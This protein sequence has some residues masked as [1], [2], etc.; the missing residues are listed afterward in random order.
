MSHHHHP[1][2]ALDVAVVS[3]CVAKVCVNWVLFVLF[4]DNVLCVQFVV[5]VNV[6]V[7]MSVCA[8]KMMVNGMCVF[9]MMVNADKHHY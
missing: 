7:M 9:G 8:H 1:L 5:M 2:D 6:N 3:V 4:V